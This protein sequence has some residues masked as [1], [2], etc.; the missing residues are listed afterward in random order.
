MDNFDPY[1][2]NPQQPSD[3]DWTPI[4]STPASEAGA[5]TENTGSEGSADHNNDWAEKSLEEVK[6]GLKQ[7]SNAIKYAFNEGRND[8]KIKQFGEDV[9]TAFEKIG[10]DIADALKKD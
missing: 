7:I 5:G 8:P 9:K 4:N 1:T 2:N 6:A 10:D 3:A